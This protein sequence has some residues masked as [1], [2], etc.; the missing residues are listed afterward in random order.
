[1]AVSID[2]VVAVSIDWV[3]AVSI[4]W[5]VAVSI[6]RVASPVYRITAERVERRVHATVRLKLMRRRELAAR[7][8][9]S[10][11]AFAAKWTVPLALADWPTVVRRRRCVAHLSSS[12]PFCRAVGAASL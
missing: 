7:R 10:C 3:V 9:H 6:D 2:W 5:V 8:A 11:F 1:M 12:L 4:D